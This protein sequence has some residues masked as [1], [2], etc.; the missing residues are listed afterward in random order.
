LKLK[1][2]IACLVAIIVLGAG[3]NRIPTFVATKETGELGS[4]PA[5]P[6]LDYQVFI[7]DLHVTLLKG[8]VFHLFRVLHECETGEPLPPF[9][10]YP[11]LG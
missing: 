8:T 6:M 7:E 2:G 10:D 3:K 9:A 11:I 4:D 5:T 1:R